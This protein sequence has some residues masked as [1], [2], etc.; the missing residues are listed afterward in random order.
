V[1]VRAFVRV[2]AFASAM[3]VLAGC[4]VDRQLAKKADAIVAEAR[5]SSLDCAVESH[6]PIDSPYRALIADADA[7][8]TPDAPV[9]YV[10]LLETGEDALLRARRGALAGEAEMHQPD[11]L[12]RSGAARPGDAGDRDREISRRVAER[13]LRHGFGGLAA[14]RTVLAQNV[15]GHA[16]HL[17]LRLVGRVIGELVAAQQEQQ[18]LVASD[19]NRP[20]RDNRR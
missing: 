5:P 14:D 6:C 20:C 13:A 16:Q 8:S 11:R 1:S 7:A 3:L 17:L 9:H 15:F 12:A 10:N 19:P 2:A 4:G 18:R